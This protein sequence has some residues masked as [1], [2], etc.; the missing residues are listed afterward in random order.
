L[1]EK[2]LNFQTT[3]V[4]KGGG[5]CFA[6]AIIS[7]NWGRSSVVADSAASMNSATT[8]HP[9]CLAPRRQQSS[10]AGMERSFSACLSAE[11]RA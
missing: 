11:Q 1:R 9:R 3:M 8:S 2:R 4:S 5:F 10:W 7:R 6:A